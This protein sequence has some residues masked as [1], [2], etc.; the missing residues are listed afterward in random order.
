MKLRVTLILGL[1]GFGATA[2][3]FSRLGAQTSE[4]NASILTGGYSYA[5]NGTVFN[6]AGTLT[7]FLSTVGIIN[8]DGKGNLTGSST[9]SAN[10]NVLGPLTFTGNYTV[11]PNCTGSMNLF[12]QGQVSPYTVVISQNGE[13]INFLGTYTGAVALGTALRQFTTLRSRAA[14]R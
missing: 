1:V 14:F 8:T 4:C 3:S 9:G 12:S 10:G 13:Q 5:L 7:G 11:Q 6:S 2:I